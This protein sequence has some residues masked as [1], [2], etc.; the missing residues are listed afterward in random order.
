MT[1]V[2]AKVG[3]RSPRSC[4]PTTASR[5]GSDDLDPVLRRR[6]ARLAGRPGSRRARSC[7]A[8]RWRRRWPR[9]RRRSR[10]RMVLLV[11]APGPGQEHHRPP[12]RGRPGAG[13]APRCCSAT[14]APA[15]DGDAMAALPEGP[16]VLVSDDAEEIA[17][18]L[19]ATVTPLAK[20]RK[21]VHWVLVG[22]SPDWESKFKRD[23][24]SAEPPWEKFVS[25]WP[26]LGMRAKLLELAPADADRLVGGVGRRPGRCGRSSPTPPTTG[27]STCW[28]RSS[29]GTGC[30]TPPS[31]AASST[32]ASAPTACP[33]TSP[34]LLDRASSRTGPGRLPV[35]GGGRGVRLRRDRHGRGRRPRRRRHGRRRR[36][37]ANG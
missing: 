22:R 20:R 5:S 6:P 13:R 3:P 26:T 17:A 11:G 12:D 16:W 28:T 31:W 33:T 30:A 1:V 32:S 7:A 8:R 10:W 25:L 19:E 15:L 23:G 2:S 34:S 14:R 36:P 18:D 9:S 37:S 27:A 29:P 35:R 4:W 21:D 24:R